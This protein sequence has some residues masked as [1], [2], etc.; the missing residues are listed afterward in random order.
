M[1]RLQHTQE[2]LGQRQNKTKQDKTRLQVTLF[3][4]DFTISSLTGN[5]RLLRLSIKGSAKGLV[6]ASKDGSWFTTWCQTL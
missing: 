5:M 2:K 6:F 3:W 1:C 4:N